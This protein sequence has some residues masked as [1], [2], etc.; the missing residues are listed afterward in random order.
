MQAG[1]TSGVLAP[2]VSA[3]PL[4]VLARVTVPFWLGEKPV[5]ELGFR[6]LR[7]I[8]GAAAQDGRLPAGARRNGFV[9]YRDGREALGE[10]TG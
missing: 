7:H 10:R 3:S 2:Y 1:D 6:T 5:V 8:G 4:G 9:V